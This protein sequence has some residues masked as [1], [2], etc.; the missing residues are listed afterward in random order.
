M[1]RCS[2]LCPWFLHWVHIVPVI[3]VRIIA[4]HHILKKQGGLTFYRPGACVYESINRDHW[5]IEQLSSGIRRR[6]L[7]CVSCV[8]HGKQT[9]F[10]RGTHLLHQST[11]NIIYFVR[12]TQLFGALRK[13]TFNKCPEDTKKG[14]SSIPKTQFSW[15]TLEISVLLTFRCDIPSWQSPV[16]SQFTLKLILLR[17]EMV[18]VTYH[19]YAQTV[20]NTTKWLSEVSN[21]DL[22]TPNLAR[23][24]VR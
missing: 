14:W 3:V 18:H 21:P 1:F 23:K 24:S 13:S 19:D 10:N 4:L 12:Q 20:N 8:I 22:S 9:T 11:Y 6:C 5:M 16:K 17:F 7:S 2:R 15:C